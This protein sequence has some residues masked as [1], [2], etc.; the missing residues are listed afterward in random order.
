MLHR[1]ITMHVKRR[2]RIPLLVILAL[3]VG[4]MTWFL[5]RARE[6]AY[7]GKPVSAWL[8]DMATRSQTGY[9]KALKSIGPAAIPYAV[10][11]LARNDS[12]W[13]KKYKELW[14]RLPKRIQNFLGKPK[15]DLQIVD[16]AN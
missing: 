8:D 3:A 14:P 11:S 7:N 2:H 1:D 10:R 13:R 15:P 9:D 4:T 5:C 12:S 16:G 6:P